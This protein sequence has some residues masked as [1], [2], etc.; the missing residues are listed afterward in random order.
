LNLT[1]IRTTDHATYMGKCHN[2]NLIPVDTPRI[3]D[4]QVL[5]GI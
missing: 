4:E 1:T 5:A 2:Y 3:L